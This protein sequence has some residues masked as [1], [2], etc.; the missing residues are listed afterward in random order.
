MNGKIRISV[1][2]GFRALSIL[3]VILYHY[4]SRWAPPLNDVSLYPYGNSF[5]FF[6]YGYLG[7]NFFFVISGYVIFFTL[8]RTD[9]L[10]S[11][12]QKRMIRLFP[13]ILFASLLTLL[14][15]SIFDKGYMFP[16]SHAFKNMIP[17]LLFIHPNIFKYI[18]D[19]DLA[20]INGSYWSLWP[21]I[22]F[23]F[24]SSIFFFISRKNFI[25]NFMIASLI[26][27][28]INNLVR[29]IHG[30]NRFHIMLSE[31]TLNFYTNW[32]SN[33]FNLV[34]YLPYFCLGVL[35]YKI[36]ANKKDGI[37][38]SVFL[39]VCFL[40]F[41]ISIIFYESGLIV[42]LLHVLI[43][44][45]FLIFIYKPNLLRFLET[46]PLTDIGESSYFLYLIH[47][48][49]G[50]Y[51]IYSAGQYIFPTTFIWPLLIIIGFS[52]FSIL[53]S[54]RIDQP[55]NKWLK[56]RIIRRVVPQVA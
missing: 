55:V 44:A 34:K 32:I 7:V 23:Y 54:R 46:P 41:A 53:F 2:D 24:I 12:W 39:N 6:G 31:E 4:F 25:R 11:F 19:T 48:N 51:L 56:S 38:N 18:F 42:R 28:L 45:V 30:S 29:N 13:S 50:V 26:M 43:I 17:S 14:F 5:A 1:L 22:Q 27:I 10:K 36:S 40:L 8:E 16:D 47:E 20:Y 9:T 37:R 49:M 3:S 15:F 33:G 35:F 52:S 21:E